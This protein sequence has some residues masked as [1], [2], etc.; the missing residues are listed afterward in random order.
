MQFEIS[1]V[2]ILAIASASFAGLTDLNGVG[3][4]AEGVYAASDFTGQPWTMHFAF[5]GAL[6]AAATD[7]DF[8][9]W[10]FTLSNGATHW[11][12]T[13]SGAE[14]GTWRSVGSNRIF[15]VTLTSGTSAGGST[16]SPAPTEVSVVYTATR[17][18]GSWGT[19]GAALTASQGTNFDAS[20]GGFL[21][22]TGS[23]GTPSA[24]AVSSGYSF[25]PAPGVLA[26]VGTAGL[27]ARRRRQASAHHA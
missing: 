2:S 24:G 12:I 6:D 9:D 26:L 5:T 15:T 27:L 7:S 21:I 10:T 23:A 16:L 18:A 11:S 1:C 22:R 19:L 4:V 3:P 8:G 13:G 17:T 25:V 14:S 20:R